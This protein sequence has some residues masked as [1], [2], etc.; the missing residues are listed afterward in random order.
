MRK[1]IDLME[2]LGPTVLY[3]VTSAENVEAC[4]QGMR[5]GSYWCTDDI[6]DYYIET[7]EDEGD[8]A[9]VLTI[10][11]DE[12]DASLLIPDHNGIEEPVTYSTM[13]KSEK[14][15]W[16]EWKA[17]D[18]SWEASLEIVGSVYYNGVVKPRLD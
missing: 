8:E 11:L 9:V 17:S 15:V 6:L 5:P 18:K 2:A 16:A 7:V 10:T 12:L 3:H 13:G 14:E 4:L 1:W